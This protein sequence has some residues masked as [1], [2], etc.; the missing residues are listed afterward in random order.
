PTADIQ[1]PTSSNPE[2]FPKEDRWYKLTV[3][4]G[5]CATIE[6]SVFVTVN[7]LPIV[8]I[9]PQQ[10]IGSG[11]SVELVASG[12]VEYTWTPEGSLDDA[13]VFN[14]VASPLV[15]TTYTVEVVDKNGCIST[16]DVTVLVQNELFIPSLFTPNGD[17]R[18]DTF[19][20]FGSGIKELTLTIYDREGNP[21]FTSSDLRLILET[22]WDGTS[23]GSML[24]NETY[25]WT[26]SGSYFDGSRIEYNGSTRG[27]IKLVR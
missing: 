17:G 27:I 13:E 10:S 6:D 25:I 11:S 14:P 22:G 5:R 2:V 20:V 9:S 12:G 1:N 15:T 8:E 18:N 23:N 7:D 26:I 19:K 3:S 4:T 24:K 21:V 16:A